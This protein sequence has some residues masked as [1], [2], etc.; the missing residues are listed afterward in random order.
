MI[1]ALILAAGLSA[2]MGRPKLLLPW[3]ETTVLGQ[4]ITIYQ[5][6]GVEDILVVTGAFRE[7]I[8]ALADGRARTVHNPDFASGEML[9]SI[10]VGLGNLSAEA[11]L[12]A[13]GDQPQVQEV[14][15]RLILEAYGD[16]RASLIVP[17]YQMR[18]GHP[19][20]ISQLH[21]AE[22][23][24]MGPPETMRDFLNQRADEIHYVSVDT[25]SI[26]QDLD[27]PQDYQE[28]KP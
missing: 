5:E 26:L 15:V 13:L 25:P 4:V 21:W 23:Q 14:S 19:W 3:G 27:T 10:Q 6:A 2:R 20:L 11:A 24:A 28:G 9:S 17:S 18:R 16:T 1:T 22:I 7:E 8:E 12:V